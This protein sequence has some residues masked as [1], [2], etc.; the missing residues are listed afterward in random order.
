MRVNS[1]KNGG[2]PSG[3]ELTRNSRV[4]ATFLDHQKLSPPGNLIQSVL[5]NTPLGYN[6]ILGGGRSRGT[7]LLC[8]SLYVWLEGALVVSIILLRDANNIRN[9]GEVLNGS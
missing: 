9:K 4:A 8:P 7:A 1:R 5:A 2:E 3:R 6:N